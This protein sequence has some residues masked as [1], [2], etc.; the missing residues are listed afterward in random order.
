[1]L[2]LCSCYSLE[3]LWPDALTVETLH[4][5]ASLRGLETLKLERSVLPVP[6]LLGA[7]PEGHSVNMPNRSLGALDLVGKA[8][9]ER[10][11]GAQREQ[12]SEVKREQRARAR[13]QRERR[14]PR[15]SAW[16]T[17]HRDQHRKRATLTCYDCCGDFC[18]CSLQRLC[19]ATTTV[20]ALMCART[21][22]VRQ[23]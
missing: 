19:A 9:V 13:Q 4:H 21:V 11:S 14:Q 23:E 15:E 16:W 5:V 18:R 8:G 20:C 6:S 12:E 17:R 1:M 10:G 2:P 7:T 3:G 22:G